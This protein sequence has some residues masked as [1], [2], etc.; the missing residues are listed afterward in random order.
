MKAI[1]LIGERG[2]TILI[3]G[4]LRKFST[5]GFRVAYFKPISIARTRLAS[6]KYVDTDV[7]AVK[8][9]LGLESPIEQISPIVVSR[10][11]L[12]LSERIDDVKNSILEAFKKVSEG[13]DIIIIE[14]YTPAEALAS[15]NCGA[16]DLAKMFG[17]KMVLVIDC[18][19]RVII[20]EIVDRTILYKCFIER[21]GGELHGVILNTVPIMYAERIRSLIVPQLEKLG[22]RV[23]GVIEERPR[24]I[25]LTV[26][27]IVEALNAEVLEGGD[28]LN[29]LVEDILIG[30]MSPEAAI[31]WFRRAVNAA[32]VTGGDRTDLIMQALETRPSTIILT[33]NLYPSIGVLI[34]ARETGTPILL[35]PYD[36]FTTVEKLREMQGIIT[37]DSLRTR[38]RDLLTIIEKEVRWRELL[39]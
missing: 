2:K 39:A 33:G 38:D 28:K 24:L 7:I 31:R 30:A 3:Y 29:S 10:S 4:L 16:V 1:Y 21:S 8:E 26:R 34:K 32:I 37:A 25:A 36:T 13:K 20:D 23:L 9:A 11:Y 22:I 15:I 12:E 5:E 19:S 6:G 18:R 35:V 27:D 14:G 17:A